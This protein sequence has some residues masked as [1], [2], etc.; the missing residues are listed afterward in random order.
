MKRFAVVFLLGLAGCAPTGYVKASEIEPLYLHVDKRHDA[1]VKND[2]ALTEAQRKRFLRSSA[3]M[4]LVL[5]EAKKAKVADS[6]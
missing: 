1:Y 3:I 4:R 2:P 5:E 6:E